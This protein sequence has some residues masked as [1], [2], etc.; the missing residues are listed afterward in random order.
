MLPCNK[1]DLP[2]FDSTVDGF[3]Y[4]GRCRV[5]ANRSSINGW[6]VFRKTSLTENDPAIKGSRAPSDQTRA[7][8]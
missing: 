2:A 6:R 4:F 3:R 5:T 7:F 1:F 8:N